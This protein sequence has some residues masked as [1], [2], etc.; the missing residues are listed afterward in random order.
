MHS[1][2][3][4]P[5]HGIEQL[6]QCEHS[7]QLKLLLPAPLSTTAALALTTS[8]MIQML[9]AGQVPM[10][11]T[12]LPGAQNNLCTDLTSM[13]FPTRTALLF[14][15]SPGPGNSSVSRKQSPVRPRQR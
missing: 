8:E 3:L 13:S 10:H 12:V 1:A 2:W 9:L 5:V 14:E 11:M 15:S 7:Q 4:H 6:G